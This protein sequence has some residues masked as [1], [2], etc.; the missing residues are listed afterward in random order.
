L[1]TTDLTEQIFSCISPRW[2]GVVHAC[3]C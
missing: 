1:L 3:M 2:N